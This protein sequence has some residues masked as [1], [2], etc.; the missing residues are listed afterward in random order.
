MPRRVC[1][2]G[3]V[4]VGA[5]GPWSER[6]ELLA[7][8]ANPKR[9]VAAEHVRTAVRWMDETLRNWTGWRRYGGS[10]DAFYG[11]LLAGYVPDRDRIAALVGLP[12]FDPNALYR[13][14]CEQ[15][16]P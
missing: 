3:E 7:C 2:P 13:S 16:S 6:W 8:V 12:P 15:P 5:Q 11:E 14:N 9:P 10:D 1:K 4:M